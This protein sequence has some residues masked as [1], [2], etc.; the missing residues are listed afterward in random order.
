MFF[1][2]IPEKSVWDPEKTNLFVCI[3]PIINDVLRFFDLIFYEDW[4]DTTAQVWKNTIHVK[5]LLPFFPMIYIK[6][7][8][9]DPLS[10][11]SPK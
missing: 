8:G 3:N 4:P 5:N 10:P 7:T 6:G 9:D 11:F 2:L 1:I